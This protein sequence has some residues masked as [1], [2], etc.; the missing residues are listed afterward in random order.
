MVIIETRIIILPVGVCGCG[1]WSLTLRK[2]RRLMVFEN[3]VLRRI[4]GPKR[5][6]ITGERRKPHNEEFNDPYSSPNVVRVIKSR[7]MR[8]SAYGG[9]AEVYTGFWCRKL[10]EIDLLEN[11]DL[12]GRIISR[13]IFRKWDVGSYTGSMWLRRGTGGGHL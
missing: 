11:T 1:T 12:D 7:R 6:D 4:F 10:M 8:W 13:W 5:D 2:E 9:R 3:R